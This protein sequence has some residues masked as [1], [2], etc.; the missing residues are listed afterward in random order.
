MD[1]LLTALLGLLV[2]FLGQLPLGN[3]SITATQIGLE[4]GFKRAWIYSIGVALV[5]M[6]YLRVALSGMNWVV[7]HKT[8]FIILN[9]VAIV[10]F[11]GLGIASFVSARKQTSNKKAV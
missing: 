7:E 1:V 10:L 11:L 8:F 6:I 2:S 3:L 5:E 9:W 4:E